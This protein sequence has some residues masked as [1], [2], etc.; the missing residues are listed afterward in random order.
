MAALAKLDFEQ[1]ESSSVDVVTQQLSLSGA[2]T[3]SKQFLVQRKVDRGREMCEA[4]KP[5]ADFFFC[6]KKM[7]LQ[8]GGV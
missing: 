4:R 7:A 1:C 5:S 2:D 3:C 6:V 8:N